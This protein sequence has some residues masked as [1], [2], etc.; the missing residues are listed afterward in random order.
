VALQRI[1]SL[2]DF[3][4]TQI[5]TRSSDDSGSG[6]KWK[7]LEVQE[8]ELNYSAN[9]AH[10]VL[11]KVNGKSE[12]LQDKIKRG[13]SYVGY[14]SEFSFLLK[15]IF[16]PKVQAEFT[17]DHEESLEGRKVC[18]L[19]YRVPQ[20]TSIFNFT[21]DSQTRMQALHG[22][23]YANCENGDIVRLQIEA[24]PV[25]ITRTITVGFVKN[26]SEISTSSEYDIHYRPTTIGPREF[27]LPQTSTAIINFGGKLTKSESQ[28][29][30]YHKFDA[31][32]KILP[33]EEGTNP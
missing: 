1:A 3:I 10:Y 8:L 21:T 20:A 5:V 22:L 16:S 31:E 13:H 28:F 27:M 24:E 18:V 19:R 26:R 12:N 32:T 11:S 6:R 9:S 30:D 25:S 2:K 17:W 14:G 33:A 7:L 29:Q 15:A 23:I 4:C